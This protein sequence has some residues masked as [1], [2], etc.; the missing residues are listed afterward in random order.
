M[1]AETEPLL[2][3][4]DAFENPPLSPVILLNT[5]YLLPQSNWN[6]RG[7][8]SPALNFSNIPPVILEGGGFL[9]CTGTVLVKE[10]N[11]ARK[12]SP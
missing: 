3:L 12:F 6:A 10:M 11:R 4:T 9:L 8:A 1:R 7:I 5:N 2:L